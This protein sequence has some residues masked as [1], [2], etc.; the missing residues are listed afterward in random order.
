MRHNEPIFTS[1]GIAIS[2][3]DDVEIENNRASVGPTYGSP[4]QDGPEP[5]MFC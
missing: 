5:S 2:I 3:S 4:N 1:E